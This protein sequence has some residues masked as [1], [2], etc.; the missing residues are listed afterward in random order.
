[1]IQHATPEP[2]VKHVDS[3]KASAAEQPAQG[4]QVSTRSLVYH[5]RRHIT[6]T[7][8]TAPVNILSYRVRHSRQSAGRTQCLLAQDAGR[9]GR[10]GPI[11]RA[12]WVRD[13]AASH[14]GVRP[15]KV[16][17]QCNPAGEITV[18]QDLE[19]WVKAANRDKD[20]SPDERHDHRYRFPGDE[21]CKEIA[22]DLGPDLL[23][24]LIIPVYT[25]TPP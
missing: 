8:S 19:H 24:K 16:A 9:S 7:G 20:L 13:T 11:K 23:N 15:V 3:G 14:Q 21:Q 18:L 6:A 4:D 5:S 17:N 22:S 25:S 10:L 1:M 12:R 2:R